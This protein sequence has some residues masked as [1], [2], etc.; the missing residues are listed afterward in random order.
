MRDDFPLLVNSD[1]VYLDNAATA[2]KPNVVLEA[3]DRF[4]REYNA[5]VHR[6]K[7]QL[8]NKATVEYE[9]VRKQAAA[10]LGA[11]VPEE[12]VFVRGTTEAINLVASS[13]VDHRFANVILSPLEHHAN[14]VP[15]QL[16]GFTAGNGLLVAPVDKQLNIRLDAFDDLCREHPGSLV[17]LTHVSNAFGIINPVKELA[18][19]AHEHDCFVLIDGAQ[20]V[21]HRPVD[22]IDLDADF[23]A[24]SG[25]KLFGPTGIGVLYGRKELLEMMP[26]YQGGGAMIETVSFE[27]SSYLPPP[28]RF[29]AGTQNLAGTVG[30]GAAMAYV[31]AV[32]YRTIGER[33]RMLTDYALKRLQEFPGTVLYTDA[34]NVEGIISFNLQGCH[35]DDVGTLMDKQGISLRTGHH[36]AMPAMEMLGIPGTVRIS[37][38]FYNTREELDRMFRALEKTAEM[39]K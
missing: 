19:I 34:P 38:A 12:I 14:I 32:G 20:G 27:G 4:Y 7:H 17:S 11:A 37:L 6:G 25:H 8:A 15:W 23:Y 18:A 1:R 2:Q 9:K 16:A 10:F 39:L 29:E 22:V 13:F 31:E 5:N 33:E 30:L 21:P 35:H 3:V 24:F 36:C 26:P 28:Y